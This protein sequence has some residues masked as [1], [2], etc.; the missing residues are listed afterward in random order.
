[1]SDASQTFPTTAPKYL[2]ILKES[3]CGTLAA[4]SICQQQYAMENATRRVKIVNGFAGLD[5]M[6]CLLLPT[7]V[8]MT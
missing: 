1:M 3:S 8:P 5:C 6:K 4:S 2:K 7:Y